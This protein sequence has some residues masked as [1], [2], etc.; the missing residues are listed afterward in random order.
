MEQFIPF[1][2]LLVDGLRTTLV[3]FALSAALATVFAVAAGVARHSGPAWL[4]WP[5][6]AVVEFFRGTSCYVQLFW[7]FYAL[8]MF[9]V[10]L[11][12]LVAS[13]TVLGLN[14]GSYGSEVV[15]GALRAVPTGQIEAA[16]ALNYSRRQS[17]IHI[18]APQALRIAIRPGANLLVDLLKLTP[19]T[20][21]VTVTDLTRSA[22]MIRNQTG[23]TIAALLCIFVAYFILASLIYAGMNRLEARLCKHMWAPS[24]RGA[25]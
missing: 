18:V 21:L 20:S 2:P 25:A 24:A 22:M 4:G 15:R 16:R 12:P 23:D 10:S 11:T 19:L 5:F 6:A 17:M 7:V 3:I 13:V 8:P 14:V 1:L 9:G